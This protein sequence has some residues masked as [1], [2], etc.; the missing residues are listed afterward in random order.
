MKRTG[1][2][3]QPVN[4]RPFYFSFEGITSKLSCR[5][6]CFFSR[7][8]QCISEASVEILKF[9]FVSCFLFSN[10]LL[11]S[12]SALIPN[13]SNKFIHFLP[14]SRDHCTAKEQ[15]WK[16][17]KTKVLSCSALKGKSSGSIRAGLLNVMFSAQSS[18]VK[19]T[20]SSF[21]GPIL[22]STAVE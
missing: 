3:S 14:L 5:V 4:K 8:Y 17:L 16:D 19:A 7:I 21:T 6:S 2:K 11:F 1:W 10:F 20:E 12:S 9:F 15:T 18:E 22:C 13:K